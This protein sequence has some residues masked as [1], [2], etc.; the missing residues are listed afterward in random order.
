MIPDKPAPVQSLPM[1]LF[2]LFIWLLAVT[3][4]IVIHEFAHGYVADRLG[5]PTPRIQGRLSINPIRHYDPIGTTMLVVSATLHAFGYPVIPLGWAKPVQFDP[6]NL[7][8]PKRDAALI[9]LAGPVTNLV[10]AGILAFLIRT[11]FLEMPLLNGLAV[12]V[13]V[14]NVAL[15]VFNLLPIHPLDGSKILYGLLPLDIAEE[16]YSIMQRYGFMILIFM[17]FPFG[18][19]SVVSSLIIPVISKI[20]NF[21]LPVGG[22]F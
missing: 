6:Y 21:L 16:Y 11:V 4:A 10:L 19:Q 14:V 3:I 1:E 22:I 20:L 17:I 5:D 18:G 7:E 13:L 8:N 15:A 9:A 2:S 12:A